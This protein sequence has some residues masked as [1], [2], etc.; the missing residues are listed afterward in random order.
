MILWFPCRYTGGG[1]WQRGF[2]QAA[3]LG[4]GIARIRG[5]R[6]ANLLARNRWTGSQASLSNS[7]RRSNV[8]GAFKVRRPVQGL[9]ILLIDDVMTTGATAGACAT[10]LKRAGA[11]SVTL[12]TLARVDRRLAASSATNSSH[13]SFLDGSLDKIAKAG[14]GLN[15]SYEPINVCAARRALVL[16]L[17][18]VASAEE[19]SPSSVHSSRRTVQ[20][21]SVIRLLEYRRIPHQTRALSRKNILMRDRYTCQYCQK[22]LPSSEMT[23]DHVIPRSRAGETTWE[24]LVAC[25]HHCNNRRAAG[26]RKKPG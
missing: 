8:S 17:K 2:N 15:A 12:L 11:K 13:R 1:S 26:R 6:F 7:D 3:Q 25:C 19:H 16:V 14:T 9:R 23:L 21:P 22:T 18:G 10:V 4:R 5:M 24:N 20:L